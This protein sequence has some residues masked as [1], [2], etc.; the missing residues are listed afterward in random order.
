MAQN[1]DKILK[2]LYKN[3][4]ESIK[5]ATEAAEAAVQRAYNLSIQ[6]A[7]SCLRQYYANYTPTSYRRINGYGHLGKAVR[8]TGIKKKDKNGL[9]FRSFGIKYVPSFLSGDYTSNS[10]YHQSGSTWKSVAQYQSFTQDNGIPEPEWILNNYLYGIH[11][12]YMGTPE[13]GIRNESVQDNETTMSVMTQFFQ[14]ELPSI[15]RGMIY[16]EISNSIYSFLKS[17]GGV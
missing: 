3:Y 16:K 11:P 1:I 7:K 4:E 15:L 17:N 9:Y 2:Q 10:W 8:G 6:K 5:I 13:S 12:R 14:K